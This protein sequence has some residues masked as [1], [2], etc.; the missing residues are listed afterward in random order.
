MVRGPEGDS[1]LAALKHTAECVC[2]REGLKGD[3]RESIQ[4]TQRA[5]EQEWKEV[6]D[7]AQV[8][9]NKA[10]IQVAL[11]KELQ[12]FNSQEENFQSWV[13]ELQG[14]FKSLGEDAPIQ[15]MLVI[16]QVMFTIDYSNMTVQY[17]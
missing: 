16:S 2:T 10:E 13:K 11:D 8:L 7:F 9:R 6:L 4:Q 1:K 12:D 3:T 5:L 15:E 14:R 17:V